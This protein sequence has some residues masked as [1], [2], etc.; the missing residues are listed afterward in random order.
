VLDEEVYMSKLAL[1]ALLTTS[2]ACTDGDI[3]QALLAEYSGQVDALAAAADTYASAVAVAGD[4]DAVSAAQTTYSDDADAAMTEMGGV[5]DGFQ[6]CGMMGDAEERVT[7]ARATVAS[8]HDAIGALEEAHADHAETSECQAAED[9]HD[10]VMQA[11]L[12]E[13]V[14]HHDAWGSTMTCMGHRGGASQ[15]DGDGS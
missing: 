11:D 3:T 4:L 7:Q 8:M 13:L 10:T 14:G 6:G 5:L 12:A 2:V 15:D 1:I 9:A